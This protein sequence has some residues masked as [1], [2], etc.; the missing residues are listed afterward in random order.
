MSGEQR[1]LLE[2]G[3]NDKAL[4]LPQIDFAEMERDAADDDTNPARLLEKKRE[5]DL[6]FPSGVL[7]RDGEQ[8]DLRERN[9]WSLRLHQIPIREFLEVQVMTIMLKVAR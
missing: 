5:L 3:W 7:S 8:L 4:R 6:Y 9:S 2:C 1:S